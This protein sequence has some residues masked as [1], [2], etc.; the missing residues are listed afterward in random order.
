[1]ETKQI[2]NVSTL[3]SDIFFLLTQFPPSLL[4]FLSLSVLSRLSVPGEPEV[5]GNILTRHTNTLSYVQTL[6]LSY[7][8]K[9][10]R[11]GPVDKKPFTDKNHHKKL[12]F[13]N[14]GAWK[15][16]SQRITDRLS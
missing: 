9:L 8:Y 7:L 12:W 16:F 1:M 5:L 11:V 13:R 2:I 14:E 15:I 10:D 6:T 4:V 3:I